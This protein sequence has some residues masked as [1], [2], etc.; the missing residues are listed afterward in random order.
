MCVCNGVYNARW[1]DCLPQDKDIR[2]IL[3]YMYEDK[4]LNTTCQVMMIMCLGT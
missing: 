3:A 4:A 2:I 1:S